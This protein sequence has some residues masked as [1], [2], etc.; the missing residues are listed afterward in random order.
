MSY[1]ENAARAGYTNE[2]GQPIGNDVDKWFEYGV[3]TGGP[4]FETGFCTRTQTYYILLF[5]VAFI[6]LATVII[7]PIIAGNVKSS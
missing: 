6:V 1:E 4:E 5:V 3:K 7:V 2:F